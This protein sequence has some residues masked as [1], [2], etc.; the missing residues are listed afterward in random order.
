MSVCCH[1][2]TEFSLGFILLFSPPFILRF[3]ITVLSPDTMLPVIQFTLNP[4]RLHF[5]Y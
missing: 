4:L 3:C 2:S 1:Y 5:R